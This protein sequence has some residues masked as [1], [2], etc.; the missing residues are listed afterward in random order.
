MTGEARQSDL[1]LGVI[2]N[3]AASALID[4]VGT[5]VWG[6]A[7]RFDSNPVFCRLLEGGTALSDPNAVGFFSICRSL[8]MSLS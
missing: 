6:C 2:G 8:S 4:R 5:L 1:Q 7:P 3:C